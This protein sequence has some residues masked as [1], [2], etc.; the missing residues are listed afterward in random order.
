MNDELITTYR[1]CR[2]IR[3]TAIAMKMN[4]SKCRTMLR[5]LLVGEISNLGSYA[6]LDDVALTELYSD[7]LSDRAIATKM[8]NALRSVSTFRIRSWRKARHLPANRSSKRQR[9]MT[10]RESFAAKHD[11]AVTLTEGKIVELLREAF[12][13]KTLGL[14][15]VE[16]QK[17]TGLTLNYLYLKFASMIE[18]GIIYK[19]DA[20]YICKAAYNYLLKCELEKQRGKD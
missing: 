16:I 19:H 18:R 15:A 14:R 17:L 1:S 5:K 10:L 7:G 6:P 11:G 3:K 8:S 13:D 2:S 9:S 20:I 12:M 4:Y